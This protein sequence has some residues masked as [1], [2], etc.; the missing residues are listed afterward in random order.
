MLGRVKIPGEIDRLKH[1]LVTRKVLPSFHWR[2][3]VTDIM[4]A[5]ASFLLSMYVS[6]I[7]CGYFVR[8]FNNLKQHKEISR[9]CS[10]RCQRFCRPGAN[11]FPTRLCCSHTVVLSR[12]NWSF[13]PRCSACILAKIGIRVINARQE[14]QLLARKVTLLR[15][16][17]RLAQPQTRSVFT[18]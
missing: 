12:K 11:R 13:S 9:N 7:V 10:Q 2:D 18:G 8:L 6:P 16:A 3:D 1:R 4:S 17:H 14:H 5:L 15:S